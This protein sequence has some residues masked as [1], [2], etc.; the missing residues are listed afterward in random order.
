MDK[1]LLEEIQGH[2]KLKADHGIHRRDEAID[3]SDFR[4]I[5]FDGFSELKMHRTKPWRLRSGRHH[6]TRPRF[7]QLQL[8]QAILQGSRRSDAWQSRKHG[9]APKMSLSLTSAG[10]RSAIE[11]R[12][13]KHSY[14]SACL[15]LGAHLWICFTSRV[16]VRRAPLSTIKSD[17]VGRPRP[18]PGGRTGPDWI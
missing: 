12:T 10:L 17:R 5:R 18:P 2:A 9:L 3:N 8:A 15:D 1:Q 7:C 11:E 14:I 16:G 6:R 13:F 4:C